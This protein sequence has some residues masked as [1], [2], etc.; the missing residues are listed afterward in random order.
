MPAASI[1]HSHVPA[2]VQPG[3]SAAASAGAAGAAAGAACAAACASFAGAGA[4]CGAT[5]SEETGGVRVGA[6]SAAAPDASATCAN[7]ATGES[8]SAS[9]ADRRTFAVLRKPGACLFM[10]HLFQ[11][12]SLIPHHAVYRPMPPRIERE[13]KIGTRVQ[14]N[15]PILSRM[16]HL[17]DKLPHLLSTIRARVHG[18]RLPLA[19]TNGP[20]EPFAPT[21]PSQP[22]RFA[23]PPAIL[24]EI[25]CE[26][27]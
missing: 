4:D 22:P 25:A 7:A 6:A 12:T 14:P 19:S 23:K 3:V 17:V 2:C 5:G 13:R 11:E 26:N 16:S 21:V 20:V 10:G 27:T 9:A 24:S 15:P 1:I 8:P 18:S